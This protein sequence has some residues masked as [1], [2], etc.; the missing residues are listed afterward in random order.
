MIEGFGVRVVMC[1]QPFSETIV[2]G[3]FVI[4]DAGVQLKRLTY[5][6]YM[7]IEEIAAA[8]G[9]SMIMV[10]E[11]GENSLANVKGLKMENV[12]LQVGEAT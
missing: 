4:G 6:A 11:E 10:A 5:A 3:G 2:Y 8:G 7:R 9:I 1:T 12:E